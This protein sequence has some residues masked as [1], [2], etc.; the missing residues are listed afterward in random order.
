MIGAG[1]WGKNFIRTIR[2]LDGVILSALCSRNSE[3]AGL[4][5]SG[6]QIVTDWHDLLESNLCDGMIIATPPD[7][8]FEILGAMIRARMPALVEKPLTLDLSQALELQRLS[9]QN[10]TPI[11]VDHIHLFHPAYVELKRLSATFAPIRSIQ[12]QAGNRGPFRANYSAL[13]DYGPHDLAMCLD[14][15]GQAPQAVA[16]RAREENPGGEYH[17]DLQF[18]GNV[19]VTILVSNV[20]D[21]KLRRLIVHGDE[22]MLTFDDV[23]A[24]KLLVDTKPVKIDETPPLLQALKTFVKGIHGETTSVFGLDLAVEV[25]RTLDR[26]QRALAR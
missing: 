12:S 4:V 11:L 26:A 3:S 24:E 25:I 6:C 7:T 15:L 5:D 21:Q 23:A 18:A 16:C 8:H 13:W 20:M 22:H 19:S 1:R 9:Q 10:R 2:D 17:L 14:L